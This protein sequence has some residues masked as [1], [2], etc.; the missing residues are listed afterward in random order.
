MTST[1]TDT[2]T[3]STVY[4][5]PE[6]PLYYFIPKDQIKRS[7]RSLKELAEMKKRVEKMYPK[8]ESV[9]FN[10]DEQPDGSFT[11]P[12]DYPGPTRFVRLQ[13]KG[14]LAEW[15]GG[16][17]RNSGDFMA[18][19]LTTRKPDDV[20]DD[21]LPEGFSRLLTTSVVNGQQKTTPTQ[22]LVTYL[23]FWEL[24]SDITREMWEGFQGEGNPP[25]TVVRTSEIE[26][27]K[28]SEGLQTRP[29]GFGK[30]LRAWSDGKDLTLRMTTP[31]Q[32]TENPSSVRN[33]RL[34]STP[35]KSMSFYADIFKA[36][37]AEPQVHRYVRCRVC[38]Y[39]SM[40]MLDCASMPSAYPSA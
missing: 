8:G 20:S 30:N 12:K 6:Q 16:D 27:V 32:E 13:E 1:V 21:S 24:P 22:R 4:S 35:V 19:I 7:D 17:E 38:T 15:L 26:T 40:A 34:D 25:V 5:M 11:R 14:R 29:T 18:D 2:K 33:P 39:V 10:W 36:D 37:I 3:N 23:S 28:L 9:K 31:L